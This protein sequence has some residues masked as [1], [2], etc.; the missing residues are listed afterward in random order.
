MAIVV[1]SPPGFYDILKH[2][3]VFALWHIRFINKSSDSIKIGAKTYYMTDYQII[4]NVSLTAMPAGV[5]SAM[6]YG[7][8]HGLKPVAIVVKSPPGI[9]D[10]LKHVCITLW[11]IRCTNK[12]PDS[13]KIGAKNLFF[14]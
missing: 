3:C 10:V 6:E 5:G 11:H 2:M 1:D 12:S 8:N 14:F 4:T 9:Q 13:K 7:L